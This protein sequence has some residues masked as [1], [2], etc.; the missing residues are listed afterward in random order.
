MPELP[1]VETVRRGLAAVTLHQRITGGDVLLARVVAG[2][3]S[4]M[5]FL[6]A[7]QG[8]SLVGWQ[9]RGKYLLAKLKGGGFLGVHLRMSGQLLWL[10][11]PIPP[12]A[13]TRVRLF[14]DSN[15]DNLCPELRF[16]DQRTFGR[17]WWVPPGDRPETIISGL[18]RL[19][20][21][22]LEANFSPDY[23]YEKLK[24]SRRP[25]K[26]VLLDQKI[27]A[28]M[29]NIYAD[30]SL[31]LSGLHP[32]AIAADLGKAE[33]IVLHQQI[34]A[35]LTQGIAAGGTTIRNFVSPDGVNGHYR[36]QA[37]VYGRKG[38]PCR[39][40]QTP[41]ARLRLGGRSSHYCPQC[42]QQ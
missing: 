6:A 15:S 14:F 2:G 41:I 36:G 1:E 38:E 24:S 25:I 12:C 20:P 30:E 21:E 17:M 32:Q 7:L 10:P 37:W 13:H 19:G 27:V 8:R 33:V 18:T 39:R 42:Q 40:C 16:V 28:G 34:I 11:E 23:L 35:V 3:V 29:G 26:T 22:P 4:P 5:N 31:F 9:R